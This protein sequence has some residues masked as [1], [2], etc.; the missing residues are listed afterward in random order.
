MIFVLTKQTDTRQDKTRQDNISCCCNSTQLYPI[1][2]YFGWVVR[3]CFFI[4]PPFIA[5]S[6]FSDE[7][8]ANKFYF[9]HKCHKKVLGWVVEVQ[10]TELVCVFC[11]RNKFWVGV[12]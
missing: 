4:F 11:F 12:V 10:Q 9:F 1:I 3:I 2:W 8:G 6:R 5:G 7:N